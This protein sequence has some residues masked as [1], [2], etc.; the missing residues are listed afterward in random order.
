[1]IAILL[2]RYLVFDFHICSC[3]KQHSD[4][5]LITIYSSSMM[6]SSTP[7]DLQCHVHGMG[8]SDEKYS[9]LTPAGRSMGE[10]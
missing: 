2:V 6:Q 4:Y 9:V 10:S 7:K 8:E 1:V 5:L 3:I